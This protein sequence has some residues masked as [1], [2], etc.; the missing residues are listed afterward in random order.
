MNRKPLF[1]DLVPHYVGHYGSLSLWVSFCGV[2][3]KKPVFFWKNIYILKKNMVLIQ[4]KIC[5]QFVWRDKKNSILNFNINVTQWRTNL[6]TQFKARKLMLFVWS[7]Q[8]KTYQASETNVFKQLCLNEAAINMI[9]FQDSKFAKPTVVLSLFS[10]SNLI[11]FPFFKSFHFLKFDLQH[12]KENL[13]L[14]HKKRWNDDMF[15]ISSS[16]QWWPALTSKY[17]SKT[18]K[19]MEVVALIFIFG[20]KN[21]TMVHTII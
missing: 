3:L 17:K 16:S 11:C 7:L 19:I 18:I 6:K 1:S 5:L 13:Q 14:K 8:E 15:F 20:K 4:K 2:I 21:M 9:Y 12:A 10:P